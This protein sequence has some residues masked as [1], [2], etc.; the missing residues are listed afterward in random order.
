MTG[1][2]FHLKNRLKK[3]LGRTASSVHWLQRQINDPYVIKAKEMGLRGR[4]YF[5]LEQLDSQFHLFKKGTRVVDLGCAPGG[6]VQYAVK[7]TGSSEKN[8]LVVGLDILPIEPVAGAVLIQQDF[9]EPEA[10]ELLQQ[11]LQGHK[12]NIVVSDMAPNT[13]GI[14]SV[15]HLRI[16]NLLELAWDFARQVLLP[17][18][19]FVGKIFEGGTESTFLAELKRNFK[20]VKHV[21]PHASRKESVEFYVVAKDFKCTT[22]K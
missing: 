4:A 9:T 12:V 17:G 21:K 8:P 20:T 1:S 11:A 22:T 10:V 19:A 18:G 5:K 15:D 6:W 13:T 3:A 2:K 16:M 7:K 14:P